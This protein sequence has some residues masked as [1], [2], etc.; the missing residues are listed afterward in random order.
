MDKHARKAED[1]ASESWQET[2]EID[3]YDQKLDKAQQY[4][5]EY[6]FEK[7]RV[8]LEEIIQI[9]Y[10][11]TSTHLPASYI[12]VHAKIPQN[13][14]ERIEATAGGASILK[15]RGY[16][17]NDYDRML[18]VAQTLIENNQAE[19]AQTYLRTVF[20][21]GNPAQRQ[22]ASELAKLSASQSKGMRKRPM[23]KR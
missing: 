10:V 5:D 14:I 4:I 12:E 17:E 6:D 7:A 9:W 15:V 20:D 11:L 2:E 16:L 22:R 21:A 18:N 13:E 8:L 23:K 3:D 1:Y 19:E